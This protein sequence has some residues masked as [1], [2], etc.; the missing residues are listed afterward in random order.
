MSNEYYWDSNYKYRCCRTTDKLTIHWPQMRS[1]HLNKLNPNR[2]LLPELDI[3]INTARDE[4]VGAG[5]LQNSSWHEE[6][7]GDRKFLLKSDPHQH[8]CNSISVHV[9]PL[10]HLAGWQCIQIL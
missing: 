2:L 7:H 4:K 3:P 8:V 6:T 9:A 5:S 1:V 10:I